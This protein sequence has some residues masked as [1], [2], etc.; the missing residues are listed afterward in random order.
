MRPRYCCFVFAIFNSGF[1]KPALKPVLTQGLYDKPRN[2]SA[3]RNLDRQTCPMPRVRLYSQSPVDSTR[4]LLDGNRTKPQTVQFIP[5]ELSGETK[6]F[7]VI[8]HYQKQAAVVLRKFYHDM[9]CL[10]MLF[11]VVECFTVNL[12]NLAADAV[13]S[14]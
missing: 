13:R 5:G 2:P 9:G 14:S 4:A 12:E 8:V 3:Q 6:A 1:A 10:R 7:A 11:Y